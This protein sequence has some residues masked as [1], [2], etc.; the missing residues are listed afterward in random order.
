MSARITHSSSLPKYR[1]MVTHKHA[2]ATPLV[3]YHDNFD[4]A[5]R[6]VR[7]KIN[8]ELE[9]CAQ[10]QATITPNACY[11]FEPDQG[12]IGGTPYLT[13]TIVDLSQSNV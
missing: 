13:I 4:V 6:C 7:I 5:M 1:Y 2:G 11:V 10:R 3:E 12:I 9:E 8:R